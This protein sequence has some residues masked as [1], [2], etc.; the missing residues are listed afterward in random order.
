MTWQDIGFQIPAAAVAVK[1]AVEAVPAASDTALDEAATRMLAIAGSASFSV[2][3]AADEAAGAVAAR[4][5]F[6]ALLEANADLVTVH[7]FTGGVGSGADYSRYLSAPDAVTSLAE[8]L[9]DGQDLPR[10]SAT[11][12]GLFVLLKA[13]TPAGLAAALAVFNGVLALDDFLWAEQRAQGLVDHSNSRMA[14]ASAALPPYWRA[15]DNRAGSGARSA[16]GAMAGY[17]ALADGH[18]A[19]N[20]TPVAELQALIGKKQQQIADTEQNYMDL[21]GLLSGGVGQAVYLEAA[22][23]GALRQALLAEDGPGYEWVM[24][25]GAGWVGSPDDLVFLREAMGL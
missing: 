15:T 3:P 7:P 12:A 2:S 10:G 4:A 21:A 25:A 24:C 19:E 9:T 14:P 13:V 17:L 11:V 23:R 18:N 16:E 20:T 8:K 1:T 22:S 5:N 6:T